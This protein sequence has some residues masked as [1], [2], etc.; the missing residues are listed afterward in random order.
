MP[1][2][3]SVDLRLTAGIP[4]VSVDSTQLAQV[5]MN[6]AANARDAMPRGGTL[7]I[8]TSVVDVDDRIGTSHAGLRPGKY[9][10]ISVVDSGV[11]IDP[12]VLP[13]VFEPFFTTKPVGQGTGL[14]LSA[15]YGIVKQSGGYVQ[16]DSTLGSGTAVIIYL[17]ALDRPVTDPSVEE[18]A[19]IRGLSGSETVLLVDDE[20]GVREFMRRVLERHGYT[21]L[22]ASDGS[23]ALDAVRRY[24]GHPQVLVTDVE[25]P[26]RQGQELVRGLSAQIPNLAV[27]YMSDYTDRLEELAGP[28]AVGGEVLQKPFAPEAL[29]R[30]VRRALDERPPGSSSSIPG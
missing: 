21:L 15:V 5:L 8:A 23:A 17:P 18:P 16:V 2:N 6:L 13:R 1:D 28:D 26:G 30:A 27:L 25:M 9:V 14:G 29:L 7:T 12:S 3:T 24:P 19:L 10:C 20:P 4:A 22:T 11:G